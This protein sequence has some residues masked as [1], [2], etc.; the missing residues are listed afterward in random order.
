MTEPLLSPLRAGFLGCVRA[1]ETALLL[2]DEERP[3]ASAPPRAPLHRS[4]RLPLHLCLYL[5]LHLCL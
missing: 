1:E 4:L 5:H 2:R 3:E